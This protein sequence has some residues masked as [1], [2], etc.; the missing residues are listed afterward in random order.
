MSSDRIWVLD[1]SKKTYMPWIWSECIARRQL[2]KNMCAPV[3]MIY[4]VRKGIVDSFYDPKEMSACSK[5]IAERLTADKLELEH[6]ALNCKTEHDK[7]M[8]V[9]VDLDKLDL[10]SLSDDQ[11]FKVYTILLKQY[12][13]V[14]KFNSIM[15][16]ASKDEKIANSF[17]GSNLNKDFVE[18]ALSGAVLSANNLFTEIG[19]RLQRNDEFAMHMTPEEM[20]CSLH[21]GIFEE[22]EVESRK[23]HYLL[24]YDGEKD[25]PIAY[26][27][28]RSRV[29]EVSFNF[30]KVPK[31]D[32]IE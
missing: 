3:H 31:N 27:G 26:V 11:L 10:V 20:D 16:A 32:L 21:G 24:V 4:N 1:N 9:A 6:L 2:P 17:S 19:E 30:N 28:E 29:M 18:E 8:Q 7:L 22:W 15:Q 12:G 13:E 5:K 14:F 25:N 23:E